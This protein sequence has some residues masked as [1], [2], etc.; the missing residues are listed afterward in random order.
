MSFPVEKN[1]NTLFLLM[2]GLLERCFML[3]RKILGVDHKELLDLAFYGLDL[4]RKVYV[5]LSL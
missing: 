5:F 4:I 3:G 2:I 1:E